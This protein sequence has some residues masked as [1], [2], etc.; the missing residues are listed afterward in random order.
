M[1][2]LTTTLLLLIIPLIT[3]FSCDPDDPGDVTA[4]TLMSSVPTDKAVDVSITTGISMMFTKKIILSSNPQ[5]KLNNQPVQGTTDARTLTI[6]ATLEPATDYTLTIPDKTLSDVAGNFVESFSISFRTSD[7]V[8]TEGTLLEAE[9]AAISNG[10]TIATTLAGYSGSGYVDMN[11]G[12]ITFTIDAA[13]TGYYRVTARYSSGGNK[14]QD[15]H[16]DGQMAGGIY[17]PQSA[18]WS[19]LELAT[20]KLTPGTHTLS[21]VKNWGYI[22]LDYLSIAYVGT[23][24]GPFTIDANLVTPQPSA[25]AIKVYNYLKESFGKNVLSGVIVDSTRNTNEARWVYEKTGKWPALVGFDFMDHTW[26]NQNWIRYDGPIKQGTD[27][28]KNNGLITLTWHWRDPLT[29]SGAFYTADTGFDI[30][31]VNDPNSNEYKAMIDDI[32]T[33]ASYLK[34][35]QQAG[36]PVLWRPLHEAA[37]GWFWWG[38]KGPGPCKTLW[39]LMFDRLVK[40]HGI[41]N[42]IW[43]WTTDVAPTAAEWYP[44]DEYVDIL[45]MDIYPGENQHGS[46]YIAFNK[47]K[48][49]FGGRKLV[50]LSEC[51]AVPDPALMLEYGDMWSWFM[52]WSGDYTR[53]DS[54]NGAAW[55]QKFFTYDH[56]ISRDEMP[57]LK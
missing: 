56:V 23:T 13:E 26:L 44:G 50:T 7:A 19:E 41:D 22:A 28:W 55:W 25:Q 42:L 2:S 15:L 11:N 31:R 49:I 37:G 36:I 46:Q 20:L 8:T 45:G 10:A 33:I 1:R 40:H 39:R 16:V 18:Q 17:F 38:A 51:G 6:Q 30:S 9:N 21:L 48:E 43:V 3:L 53:S 35:F 29:K 47:V 4:P 54:H 27:Y 24:T 52:V 32:D 34:E 12:N 57:D 14:T 5:L